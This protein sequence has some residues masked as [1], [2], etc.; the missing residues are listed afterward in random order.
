MAISIEIEYSDSSCCRNAP[1]RDFW[2]NL[3]PSRGPTARHASAQQLC[4]RASVAWLTQAVARTRLTGW[5]RPIVAFETLPADVGPV[6]GLRA[7]GGRHP[8]FLAL[9]VQ[10]LAG[11]LLDVFDAGLDRFGNFGLLVLV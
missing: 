1:P 11:L 2:L 5:W 4:L 6:A 9:V 10:Q 3:S 8:G 7:A